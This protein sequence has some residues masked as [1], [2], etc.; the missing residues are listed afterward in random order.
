MDGVD[1]VDGVVGVGGRSGR[2]DEFF[3]ATSNTFFV[4]P[5]PSHSTHSTHSIHSTAQPPNTRQRPRLRRSSTAEGRLGSGVGGVDGVGG[6]VAGGS[7]RFRL[8]DKA[9]PSAPLPLHPLHPLHPPHCSAS[10]SLTAA[11]TAAAAAPCGHAR[12]NRVRHTCDDSAI[13]AM[14]A[15]ACAAN[16]MFRGCTPC[17]RP[18]SAPLLLTR[19]PDH[20]ITRSPG[21][22]R[23]QDAPSLR[24]PHRHASAV[25]DP[26]RAACP[27]ARPAV[28]RPSFAPMLPCSSPVH[29]IPPSTC[30]PDHLL[31]LIPR[32]G[33]RVIRQAGSVSEGSTGGGAM[34]EVAAAPSRCCRSRRDAAARPDRCSMTV[35]RQCARLRAQQSPQLYPP[36]LLLLTCRRA[37]RDGQHAQTDV[38]RLHRARR[39]ARRRTLN[40]PQ[41]RPPA[42]PLLTR[43]PAHT[44]HDRMIR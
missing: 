19:T 35:Q 16:G 9:A 6:R 25:A 39:R 15:A 8:V 1:G 29:L 31:T 26:C 30:S 32:S 21:C 41:P 7:R 40:S 5:R 42:Q 11:E 22:T 12:G 17:S 2:C 43:P 18:S 27:G 13:G 3:I 24:R 20:L 33:D 4:S 10:A 36:H 14:V 34:H 38:Q 23:T 37:P 28:N 44:P